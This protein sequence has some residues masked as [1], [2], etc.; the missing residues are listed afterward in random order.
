MN[1]NRTDVLL[2]ALL[3][4]QFQLFF[5]LVYSIGYGTFQAAANL[6]SIPALIAA[7]L[8]VLAVICSLQGAQK[9]LAA[10]FSDQEEKQSAARSAGIALLLSSLLYVTII[11]I[12]N[13]YTF[14][15]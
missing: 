5:Q 2:L 11:V 6:T 12:S 3:V 14:V 7:G 15:T 13:T 9:I 4:I 10:Y 1:V 8:Y